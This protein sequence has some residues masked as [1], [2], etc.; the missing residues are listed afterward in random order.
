LPAT[1]NFCSDTLE[2]QS[3]CQAPQQANGISQAIAK[4]YVAPWNWFKYAYA[5]IVPLSPAAILTQP[6]L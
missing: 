4:Q 6:K 1:A 5:P 3:P 2:K